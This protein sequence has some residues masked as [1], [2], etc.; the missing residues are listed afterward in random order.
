MTV[1]KVIKIDERIS[2]DV[3]ADAQTE[4]LYSTACLLK[5]NGRFLSILTSGRSLMPDSAVIEEENFSKGFPKN[6]S[7]NFSDAKIWDSF[8]EKSMKPPT[9]EAI[10]AL[11]SMATEKGIRRDNMEEEA[12]RKNFSSLIGRGGGLTPSGDDF[13]GGALMAAAAFSDDFFNEISQAVSN[14][15]ANTSD[16]SAH[17]LEHALAGRG[18]EDII[19]LFRALSIG[20]IKTIRQLFLRIV[21]YGETS[22][23]FII[24][25]MLWLLQQI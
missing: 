23:M 11:E 7:F 16:L 13:L 24:K 1:Y 12:D 21:S 20:D 4:E 22:G 2:Q 6:R 19:L 15:L 9:S 3:L 8:I 5:H 17:F 10:E 18:G 14:N 25:G